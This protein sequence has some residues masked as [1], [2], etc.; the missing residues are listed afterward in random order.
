MPSLLA[1][2]PLKGGG[3]VAAN[4]GPLGEAGPCPPDGHKVG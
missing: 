2:A 1:R 4:W 3:A